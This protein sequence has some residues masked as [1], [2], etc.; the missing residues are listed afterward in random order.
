MVINGIPPQLSGGCGGHLPEFTATFRAAGSIVEVYRFSRNKFSLQP[1]P[2][3]V[4]EG[5]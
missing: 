5:E 4:L 3:L 1:N 2:V